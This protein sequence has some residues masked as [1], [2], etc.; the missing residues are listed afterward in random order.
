MS[1]DDYLSSHVS[2]NG[3]LNVCI[4]INSARLIAVLTN[5]K[6]SEIM[7]AILETGNDKRIF[8]I[9]LK[10]ISSVSST[11]KVNQLVKKCFVIAARLCC[12]LFV[13]IA[14]E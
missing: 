2:F 7:T 10:S 13:A 5:A 9:E 14:I 1:S 6:L 11:Y 4:A 3:R 12:V 8:H